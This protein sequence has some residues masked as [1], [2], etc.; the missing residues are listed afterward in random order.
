MICLIF[1][2]SK[3][4]PKHQITLPKEVRESLNI[5]IGDRVIFIETD[6]G[7]L[8]KKV[9]EAIVQKIVEES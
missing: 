6:E 1:E 5:N 2:V 4:L 7:F 8:L 9:D 3:I